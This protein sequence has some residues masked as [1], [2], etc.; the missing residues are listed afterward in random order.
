MQTSMFHVY[1]GMGVA[2][3][4]NAQCPTCLEQLCNPILLPCGHQFCMKCVSPVRATE[5]C[6]V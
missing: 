3:D 2:G 1:T 6:H 4:T 5:L